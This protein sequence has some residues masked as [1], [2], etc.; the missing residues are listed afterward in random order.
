M[1]KNKL[2][3]YGKK[4]RKRLI[5]KNMTQVELANQLGCK[6]QYI[7]QI[8]SGKKSGKKYSEEINRILDIKEVRSE[9]R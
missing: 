1:R 6:T 9:I 5:D 7:T 2:T 8:L 3:P 4:I